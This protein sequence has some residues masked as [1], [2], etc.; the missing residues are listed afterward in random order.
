ML[1]DPASDGRRLKPG[2]KSP[3]KCGPKKVK[4][5]VLLE[6][7]LPPYV[8]S[9]SARQANFGYPPVEICIGG[10]IQLFE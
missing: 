3:Q 9:D 7:W 4:E 2:L 1:R 10:I 5:G 6:N 8:S